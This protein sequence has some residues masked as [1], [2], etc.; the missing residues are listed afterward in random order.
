MKKQILSNE[1]LIDTL[2]D[3]KLVDPQI[4]INNPNVI[5]RP[6]Y[7]NFSFITNFIPLI[8]FVYIFTQTSELKVIALGSIMMMAILFIIYQ[9]LKSYNTIIIKPVE[10]LIEIKPNFFLK[11]FHKQQDL[12]FDRIKTIEYYSNSF[13]LVYRRYI[14]V[15]ILKETGDKFK[16]IS[17]SNIA[18][19][20]KIVAIL[21]SVINL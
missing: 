13:R 18:N 6:F 10:N 1:L 14:I 17:T 5:I 21:H 15:I 8:A 2:K 4:T 3:V 19:A 9:Q 7:W 20:N 11:I 12:S 16:I